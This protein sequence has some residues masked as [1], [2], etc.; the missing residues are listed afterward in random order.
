[1]SERVEPREWEEARYSTVFKMIDSGVD[2]ELYELPISVR[3]RRGCEK[4]GAKKASDLNLINLT[5]L[6]SLKNVGPTTVYE[7]K[8]LRELM[9]S[10]RLMHGRKHSI[11]SEIYRAIRDRN[12]GLAE[13]LCIELLEYETRKH[14][15]TE[16]ETDQ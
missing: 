2:P 15:T 9:E 14:R 7:V 4:L 3:A 10:R 16:Q 5:E 8:R 12:Y 1:M 13:S 11:A 6:G